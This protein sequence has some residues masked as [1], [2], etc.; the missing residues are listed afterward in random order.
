MSNSDKEDILKY[1]TP[2][3]TV[4]IV[5]AVFFVLSV[6][7]FFITKAITADNLKAG[8]VG[9][10]MA[11]MGIVFICLKYYYLFAAKSRLKQAEQDGDTSFIAEDFRQGERFL[12]NRV[13]CGKHYIFSGGLG[14]IVRLSDIKEICRET[15]YY[16]NVPNAENLVLVL[17]NNKKVT[18]CS[19]S[20]MENNHP[21]Y[22]DI[23]RTIC[24]Y[25]PDVEVN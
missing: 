16:K 7:G 19:I 24:R 11:V 22:S 4:A 2:P 1:V 23:I 14:L 10:V 13:I 21:P 9:G 6:P 25:Q 8:V 18:L 5:G 15:K 3:S 17:R 20:V 12:R